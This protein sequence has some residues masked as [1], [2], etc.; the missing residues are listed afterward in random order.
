MVSLMQSDDLW[1]DVNQFHKNLSRCQAHGHVSAEIC[2]DCA[3]LLTEAVGLYKGDFLAGFSLKD[4]VN[5][6]DWQF[7]QAQSVHSE[8][9]SVVERLVRYHSGRG[10]L[11]L[12][13]EHARRWLGLDRASESAH[14]HLIE[15]Y[16]KSGQRAAALRQYDECVRALERWAGKKPQEETIRLYKAVKDD[17]TAVGSPFRESADVPLNNPSGLSPFALLRAGSQELALNGMRGR[18]LPR[19]LTSFIGREREITEVK[20][21]IS[22]SYLLTLTGSGGCGKTRLALEVAAGLL[23][24]FPD[25]VWFVEFSALSNP[26]LVPQAVVGALGLSEQLGRPP[27]A[28]LSDYLQSKKILLVLDN[29]EHLI[30]ACAILADAL[31]RSCPRLRILATSREGLGIAG[32]TTWRVPSLST[33][34]PKLF[35]HPTQDKPRPVEASTLTQYES[36]RLFID[37]AEALLPGFTATD[38]NA[39]AVAEICRRLDGIPLAIEL[40]AACVDTLSVGEIASQLGDCFRLLT[41]GSRT[42]PPRQQTL[43]AT[44]DWSYNL[45]S[46]VERLLLRR[47]SV[48]AGG[49]T[50][51]GAEAVCADG[52]PSNEILGLLMRLVKKS[53]V[54]VDHEEG[55]RYRLLETIR[56]YGLEKLIEAGEESAV[57]GRH[58][59]WYLSLAERIEPELRGADQKAW[60]DRLE[61][62]HDNLRAALGWSLEGR[63]VSEGLRLAGALWRFWYVRGYLSEGCRWLERALEEGVGASASVRAKAL[64]GAGIM[65]WRHEDYS[66]AKAFFEESIAL[67]RELGDKWGMAESLRGLGF[68]ARDRS[69]YKRAAALFEE[70]LSLFKEIE[71][72]KGIV[73]PLNDLG[74]V[75]LSQGEYS[76]AMARCEESLSLFRELGDGWGMA[77]SLNIL[78][79]T[80]YY[81]GY[82]SRSAALFEESLSLFQELG[83]KHG[84]AWCL[85]GLAGVAVAQGQ[86]ER[87]AELCRESLALYSELGNKKDIPGCLECLA[88]AAVAQR[89]PEQAA[90]LFGTAE[91]LRKTAGVPLPFPDRADYDRSVAAVRE[92]L[93][94]EAFRVLWEEGRRMTLEEAIKM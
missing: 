25:G 90:R 52:V 22:T 9:L 64:C 33:P 83:D 14:R 84:I 55:M 75:A 43:R 42:A 7:F 5:F 91:A 94:E 48:F 39:A 10:E 13:I 17:R 93:G 15:L 62:E 66:R 76:L 77:V 57:R 86:P 27:L 31:M 46:E 54:T 38:H 60:L 40:A 50:L 3:K 89:Q 37:R 92:G 87:A 74:V 16:A 53:L 70:S 59:D 58:R 21:L 35:I 73:W 81:Q 47:L 32:E 26:S 71:D 56:Q 20:R 88:R 72:K 49:F 29:C 80:A 68:V 19:Q 44:M 78:G 23:E 2:P 61:V 28:T 34:D 30:E 79:S 36:V 6:D 63:E 51:D 8:M 85:E 67:F 45:L 69:D 4:S 11:E 18:S 24:E 41:T 12:A 82:Y 65:M 1:L